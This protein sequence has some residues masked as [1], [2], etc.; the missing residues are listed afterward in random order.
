[1]CASFGEIASAMPFAVLDEVT[2]V[3]TWAAQNRDK[4]A[5]ATSA[6]IGMDVDAVRVAIDRSDLTVGPVTRAIAAQLQETA[7]VF[8]KL[9]FIPKPIVVRDAVWPIA[10]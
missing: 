8:L 3:T 5:E 9:G 6:A 10:G 2:N 4:F 1:M 7:D